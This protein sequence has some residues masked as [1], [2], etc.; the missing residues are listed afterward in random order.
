MPRLPTASVAV[1]GFVGS[2][3]ALTKPIIWVI[4]RLSE[5]DF[6]ATYGGEFGRFLETGFGT[7]ASVVVG[8]AIIGFSIFKGMQAPTTADNKPLAAHAPSASASKK[9]AP[10]LSYEWGP[11]DEPIIEPRM[12]T[13]IARQ[14]TTVAELYEMAEGQEVMVVHYL[15][16]LD[17]K[18]RCAAE[19]LCANPSVINV[20]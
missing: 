14:V 10:A 11:L 12:S 7:L 16:G 17:D 18:T 1:V 20:R 9:E 2:C 8:C 5:M 19:N 4:D 6:L 13:I 15:S 3:V